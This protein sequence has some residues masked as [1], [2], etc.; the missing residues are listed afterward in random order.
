MGYAENYDN[1]D[2]R[3]Q[4]LPDKVI[5][6]DHMKST[7]EELGPNPSGSFP[8]VTDRFANVD[9]RLA[10][11]EA[12]APPPNVPP[13][14]AFTVTEDNLL[15]SV[16]ASTSTDGDGT[17]VSYSWNWGDGTAAA[18]GQLA[19]HVYAAGGTY[20]VTLT[21][22]DDAGGV[23]TQ[24]ASVTVV[25]NIAPVALFSASMSNLT[26]SVDAAAA[27]DPDG[28]IVSY[29][30]NWGD[31]TATGS[32]S[33]ASH[34]Y[35]NPG[36][37][38]VTLTVT[39]QDGATGTLAQNVTA[40][41]APVALA[42]DTFTRTVANGWGTTSTGSQAWT[43][44]N[45]TGTT[46]DFAANGSGGTI[47]LSAAGNRRGLALNGVS[48]QDVDITVS[49][50]FDKVPNAGSA[51]AYVCARRSGSGTAVN[52]YRARIRVQPGDVYLQ[53]FKVL[54]GASE[55]Q[56]GA[57]NIKIGAGAYTAGDVI[58]VRLLVTGTGTTRIRAKG[59]YATDTE[60]TL[61][62][63][64]NTDTELALQSA[65]AVGLD[66]FLATATNTPIVATFDDLSVS[67]SQ[68]A[69][70]P[71]AAATLAPYGLEVS[72]DASG[73]TDPDGTIASYS[74]D[75]GDSTTDSTGVTAT[76]TYGSPGTYTVTLTVTD[77]VGNVDTDVKSLT[78]A[79]LDFDPTVI[80]TG[81]QLEN[82][83]VKVAAGDQPW[84]REW[85]AMVASSYISRT[86]AGA[87]ATIDTRPK[88]DA[89]ISDSQAALMLALSWYCNPN[90]TTADQHAIR[91]IGILNAY[92]NNTTFWSS[93]DGG[94]SATLKL[95]AAWFT[96]N[97][98]CAAEIIRGTYP[99]H[100]SLTTDG[101]SSWSTSDQNG[102]RSFLQNVMLRGP[103]TAPPESTANANFDDFALLDWYTHRLNGWG[104]F[105]E[106]RM[107]GWAF[108]RNTVKLN[109]TIQDFRDGIAAQIYQDAKGGASAN[110]A[111]AADV[112]AT[113][114]AGYPV[115][116]ENNTIPITDFWYVP[117]GFTG[118]FNGMS[119]ESCR[120]HEHHGMGYIDLGNIC[121]IAKTAA[122][123]DLW[124]E[125]S[126]RLRAGW[127]QMAGWTNEALDRARTAGLTFAGVLN[128]AS[129]APLGGAEY[130]S[131]A[132]P[133]A[134]SGFIGLGG[135]PTPPFYA[136]LEQAFREYVIDGGFHMPQVERLVRRIRAG[137]TSRTAAGGFNADDTGT[138]AVMNPA[139]TGIYDRFRIPTTPDVTLVGRDRFERT[140][141]SGWGTAD[142]GGAWSTTA[143]SGST[144][145]F[146]VS[147]GK[148]RI[149]Q[150]VVSRWHHAR[151]GGITAKSDFDMYVDLQL[152]AL[153]SVSS[154]SAFLVARSNTSDP[155]KFYAFGVVLDST[156]ALSC[157]L[158]RYDVVG[159]TTIELLSAVAFTGHGSYTPGTAG[160]DKI[161]L[162]MQ[163]NTVSGTEC[164][165]RGKAWIPYYP[166]P[167]AWRMSANDTG[168]S[169]LGAVLG[170]GSCG[171]STFSG[172]TLSPLT[173]SAIFDNL[174]VV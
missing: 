150:P 13:T 86:G 72:A 172:G 168:A 115:S 164:Q 33:T 149:A 79:A 109:E 163:V 3:F 92:K 49:V 90:R 154:V 139:N 19:T 165:V 145:D 62:Q 138:G 143:P 137:Q 16:N 44:V 93:D 7:Y 144:A 75:W 107:A 95:N 81:T 20:T 153:P 104:C 126:T 151:Q 135:D 32:G 157:R 42:T 121:D 6:A 38:T 156:G 9:E 55:V 88:A 112:N 166:E 132:Y 1:R 36:T 108:L 105:V 30:W 141:S 119:S 140:A 56:I 129:W 173:L 174:R 51:R 97:I 152:S 50:K 15:I 53:I 103:S 67:S 122:G 35:S 84:K 48:V 80:Y 11:L 158:R 102:F 59:W 94:G 146:S 78:V 170:A 65:G 74:W 54:A 68:L 60:P 120:D 101:T 58:K 124:A 130:D 114:G 98:A 123:V 162:R 134:A 169:S 85:D 63:I 2:I 159:G 18:T 39:D 70:L 128:E 27:Y 69:T 136:G 21:V 22:V 171:V 40:T 116:P 34:T 61:W 148:G 10:D 31:A 52:D 64:D 45:G 4:D 37:Y 76:H 113:L 118:W 106:A 8:S 77:N 14:A 28:T 82:L 110:P 46:G 133:E 73:S 96:T 17:I 47:S 89:A 167:V 5:Y 26:V 117:S 125:F 83:R 29:S 99:N 57:T 25:P 131:F 161:R 66:T 111:Q 24:T 43:I 147:S 100:P 87:V 71:V 155:G 91:A 160:L 127:E 41:A 23:D 12:A 142:T